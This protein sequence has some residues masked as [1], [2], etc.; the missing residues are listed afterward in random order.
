MNRNTQEKFALNPINID[1]Q[2]SRFTMNPEVKTTF[3]LGQIVPVGKPIEILP[4]DT[5]E[6]NTALALR[7][8]PFACAPFGNITLSLYWFFVP[9]R[10]VWDHWKEFMGENTQSEWIPNTEYTIPQL[11]LINGGVPGSIV[12]YM[13]CPTQDLN[14]ASA[15]KHIN[16]DAC[17]TRG[18]AL[19]YNEFFRN[20]NVVPP[21]MVHT[22]DTYRTGVTPRNVSEY[23]DPVIATELG[24]P[25]LIASKRP[26]LFVKALPGPQKGPDLTI[27]DHMP[28]YLDNNVRPGTNVEEAHPDSYANVTV[29]GVNK[30]VGFYD[31]AS[32]NHITTPFQLD[33]WYVDGSLTIS[34]LRTAFQIQKLYEK[35]ARGGRKSLCLHIKKIAEKI[36]KAA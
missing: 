13:G 17:Y 14:G 19:I 23:N 6:V 10:L 22:D 18:Y 33:N 34:A 28:V 3:Q 27:M 25:L 20:Q 8:M 29:D 7:M 11:K 12:D 16:I 32:G 1:I 24:G 26:D 36:W 31:R 2:R 21:V 5:F 4:G 35:D 15:N 30:T 9:R